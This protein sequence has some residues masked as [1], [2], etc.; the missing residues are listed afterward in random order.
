MVHDNIFKNIY[1]INF[2]NIE[3][4]KSCWNHIVNI[5]PK[6]IQVGILA[7]RFILLN[8]LLELFDIK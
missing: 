1:Y 6:N 5:H 8:I 3:F 7:Q 4:L 2:Y